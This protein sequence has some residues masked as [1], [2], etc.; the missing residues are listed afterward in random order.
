[1]S[2][3]NKKDFM[4]CG[5]GNISQDKKVVCQG[6]APIVPLIWEPIAQEEEK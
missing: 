5:L 1:M 2:N 4:G 6:Y 3:E